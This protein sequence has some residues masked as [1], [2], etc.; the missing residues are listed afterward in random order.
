MDNTS[1]CKFV[2]AQCKSVFCIKYILVSCVMTWE[3]FFVLSECITC[4][5]THGFTLWREVNR[6]EEMQKDKK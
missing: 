5:Y 2:M 3:S 6:L 4:E 1:C